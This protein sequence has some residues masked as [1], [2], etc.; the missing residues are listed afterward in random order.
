MLAS[1]L[2][3]ASWNLLAKRARGGTGFLYLFSLLTVAVYGPVALVYVLV[4]RPQF[5]LTHLAF[6]LGSSVI[7]VGY[8]VFLQRGYKVGDLSLV[9]P[10]ARGSGP[11]LA[12]LLAV[13]VLG[14]RPGVQAL[15]GTAIVV[16]S[17][18]VLS[19]G[20]GLFAA[21][22]RSAVVYGLVTGLFIGIYTVWDGYAVG[23]LM[24][25]PLLFTFTGEAGRVLVLAPLMAGRR[26]EIGAAW[27]E[28]KLEALGVAVLSPLAYLMVLTAM[29]FTPISLVA[30][31]RE[32]SILIGA[33]LG[34]R[35][36]AEGEGNR[37]LLGAVGMVIG[38]ALLATG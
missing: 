11:A 5:T 20:S 18:F 13:L 38:V 29:R 6:A 21:E 26:T 15:A 3:H 22:R 37:R 24:A 8:F 4:A 23:V 34:T 2:L 25:A 9:Y 28:H 7:H 14:E 19:G 1:A 27:R 16:V 12:T 32:V 36:L 17:V 35:L 10:L 30:P 31:T 33:L